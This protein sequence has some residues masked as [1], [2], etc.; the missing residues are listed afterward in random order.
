MR[1]GE[2]A[3]TAAAAFVIGRF[4]YKDGQQGWI[5]IIEAALLGDLPWDVHSYAEHNRDFPDIST[6][7]QL[8][9]HRDFEAYRMLGYT[10]TMRALSPWR[11]R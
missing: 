8:M 11:R 7:Y 4:R 3:P 6:G 5:T 9:D 10:Q 1:D 2:A